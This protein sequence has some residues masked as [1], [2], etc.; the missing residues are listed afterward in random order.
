MQR[1]LV[2][3]VTQAEIDEYRETGAV[4]LQGILGEPWV[5]AL[6]PAIEEAIY[7]Q[8]GKAVSYDITDFAAQ[9]KSM[10]ELTDERAQA[11]ENPGRFLT[12]IGGWTTTPSLRTFALES[13]LGFIA[14]RLFGA[15]KVAFY[16]DQILIKEPRSKQYT[17]FHTDEPYYHLAGQQICGIWVSPDVVDA[18][19]SAMQY[20]RGSHRW[21][22]SF[23]PNNFA[24]QVTLAEMGLGQTEAGAVKLPDIEGNRDKYDIVTYP[25]NPGDV[26][27]HHSRLIH[28]SG[29]NYSGRTRRAAS[30]RYVGDDV[31]Y[32][33]QK[34]APPQ[35]HHKHSLAEGDPIESEMFPRVWPV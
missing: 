6:G 3:D 11:L 13:P 1:G 20:V 15:K 28:G 30:F 35:P 18:D 24:N 25:S 27:V 17:A 5:S 14:S 7:K 16:D 33:F 22:D 2:R 21:K 19:S 4:R 26:L 9:L 29:P 12:V 10:G 31:T 23:L 32:R 8:W 34:M